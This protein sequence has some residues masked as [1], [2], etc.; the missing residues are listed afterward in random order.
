M[1]RILLCR[2]L[3]DMCRDVVFPRVEALREKRF[4]KSR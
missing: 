2:Y 4:V 3:L 1:L